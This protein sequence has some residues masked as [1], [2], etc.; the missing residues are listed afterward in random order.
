MVGKTEQSFEHMAVMMNAQADQLETI[1]TGITTRD[2]RFD[3]TLIIFD[4]TKA[5]AGKEGIDDKGCLQAGHENEFSP[6]C[7]QCRSGA[8]DCIH[9]TV[10]HHRNNN[11]VKQNFMA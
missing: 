4:L 7:P 9:S 6:F 11:Q 2:Y 1:Y 10:P 8:T 3:S 5:I